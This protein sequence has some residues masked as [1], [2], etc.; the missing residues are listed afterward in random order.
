[1]QTLAFSLLRKFPP[2]P[3]PSLPLEVD[4]DGLIRHPQHI[5]SSSDVAHI[6]RLFRRNG[7]PIRATTRAGAGGDLRR[8]YCHAHSG[9]SRAPP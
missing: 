2:L 8:P 5:R 1:M 6:L 9:H 7:R 4:A 3:T